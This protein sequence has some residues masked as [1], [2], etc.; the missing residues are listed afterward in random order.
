M[1]PIQMNFSNHMTILIRKPEENYETSSEQYLI[2]EDHSQIK[3][4]VAGICKLRVHRK[5]VNN[6]LGINHCWKV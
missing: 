1:C 6:E 4:R 2:Y 5:R 3:N